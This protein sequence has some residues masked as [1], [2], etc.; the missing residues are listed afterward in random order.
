[1]YEHSTD[2]TNTFPRNG[3][4]WSARDLALLKINAGKISADEI[5]ITFAGTL[6]QCTLK[7]HVSVYH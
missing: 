1:M 3:L 7:R 6:K 4:K 5:A 2:T